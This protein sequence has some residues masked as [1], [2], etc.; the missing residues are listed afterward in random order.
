MAA[1]IARARPAI[2]HIFV[3]VAAE[4]PFRIERPGSGVV[5]SPDGLVLTCAS[6]V[7]EVSAGQP[8]KRLYVQLADTA[9]TRMPAPI[10]AEDKVTG[11]ALLRATPAAGTGLACVPLAAPPAPGDPAVVCSY[12]DGEDQVAFAGV[13]H[14][15]PG[16]A[17]L[18]PESVLLTDAAIQRRSHGAALLDRTGSLLGIC[19]AEH[20]L[21]DIAEP[22]LADLR[23]PSF[24]YAIASRSCERAFAAQLAHVARAPA[25]PPGPEAAA[26]AAVA[27]AIVG[28]HGEFG[29][30]P[31]QAAN[32][33]Y[34]RQRRRG[35]GSGV[36][37]DASGLV[38][39]NR[40]LVFG[41]RSVVVTP[42]GAAPLPAE[43]LHSDPHTNSALLRVRLAAGQT[44]PAAPL[45]L[46]PEPAVGSRV[47]AVAAPEAKGLV[48]GGGVLSAR[49]GGHLQTDAP[50]GNHT[51][52]GA[53]ITLAGTVL[54]LCDG[55][56]VDKVEAAFEERGDQA[57]IDTS[58]NLTPG[59]ARLREVYAEQLARAPAPAQGRA[60]AA[61][62]P[63]PV[64]AVGAKAGGA[65][66]NVYVEVKTGAA[67][68][69][70]NPFAPAKT[71]AVVEGM[72]SGVVIDAGG[73]ALT[74]WHVVDSATFPDGSTRPERAV[75]VSLRDGRTFAA[76]V[77]SISREEDL[78]LLQLEIPAGG[79][80]TPIEFGNSA[81]LMV[82]DG[83]IAIGNPHG[84][85]N[86]VTA[87]IVVAKN[88]AIRVK[89]R[90]AK[91][92]HLLETDAAINAG[93]SGGPLLDFAG[94][95]IGINSAGGSVHAVT[96]FAIAA[97]HVRERLHGLLLTPEKLRASYLGV[98][99]VDEPVGV[100]V[101]A[102]DRFSPA[103]LA[104][105]GIGD[106]LL[107]LDDQDL[108]SSLGLAL[109]LRRLD[110]AHPVRL[111][112]EREGRRRE[113]Q[114]TAWS[115]ATRALQRQT[116]LVGLEH[117]A[118]A[119]VQAA[120][121]ALWRQFTGD[122]ASSPSTLPASLVRV[123]QVDP[124]FAAAGLAL[125][126]GDLLLGLPLR[127][128]AGGG[129]AE[130]LERFE[131]VADAVRCFQQISAYEGTE[132]QVWIWRE[133]RLQRVALRAKRLLP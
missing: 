117:H 120:A 34:A 66:L 99:A 21:P 111:V 115:A 107:R 32:D 2:V 71:A 25:Q 12:H 100:V 23:K 132:H 87:G 118:A 80:V 88:Q 41:A 54:G 22:T 18:A 85:A 52:G 13:V 62:L 129:E 75:R 102:L 56:A 31:E 91:L 3:E 127:E 94:R 8:D 64:A 39:T 119:E 105:I 70:D 43:V 74:N 58:L 17:P 131:Q 57:K 26:V 110:A 104:G 76:Q 1:A 108:D 55:G 67:T 19:S 59:I 82:G 60:P 27:P 103:A 15:A 98:V 69:E 28:V 33:P 83:A 97:D 89:G 126:A 86:T 133:G 16:G 68:V 112:A 47:L 9:R 38:L 53:L 10:V 46:G 96:G 125:R 61:A 20:V 45:A 24:G 48:V 5:V 4:P 101:R 121:L 106:R 128:A 72:G 77:L 79:T 109:R 40:H 44:L 90:W 93:N 78:A 36:V 63:E 30:R 42:R 51:A 6:L 124:E 14:F 37:I 130:R 35:V 73:L 81:A 116:G 84:R 92:P 50:L 49:R 11:L 29:P 7:Q 123:A 122:P 65:V 95:L 114:L 113:V